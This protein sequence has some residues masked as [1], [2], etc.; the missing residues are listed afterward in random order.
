MLGFGDTYQV[1]V[2][3]QAIQTEGFDDPKS[4]LDEGFG[5]PTVDNIPWENDSAIRGIDL[6]TA[7]HYLNGD[8]TQKITKK[9]T[10]VIFGLNSE[11]PQIIN[12]YDGTLVDVE[13]D[14]DVYAYYVPNGTNYD[15]YFLA[16]SDIYTPVNSAELMNGMTALTKVDT[17]NL[18]VSRTEDMTK[19][20]MGCTVLSDIDVSRWDT[21]NVTSLFATFA[22]CKA[23]TEPDMDEWDTSNVTTLRALFSGC[24]ALKYVDVGDWNTSKVTDMKNIF[25]ACYKLTEVAGIGSWDTSNVTDMTQAFMDC[26]SLATLDVSDWNVGKVTRFKATFA[27]TAQNTGKM[28]LTDLDVTDWDVS[29]VTDLEAMFYGCGQITSMDLS[30]WDVSKVTKAAHMFSDC[31][32]LETINVSGWNTSSLTCLDAMFNDC[33]SLKVIDVS[34]FTTDKVKEFSQMFEVCTSL[35]KIIGLENWNTT[36]G[37]DFSEMFHGCSSLKELDLSSFDTRQSNAGYITYYPSKNCMFERFLAGCTSLEKISFS[38]NVS[39]DG[40]GSCPAG[41]KLVMPASTGVNGWDGNWYHAATGEAFAP[42]DIPE[43]TA[44]TYVAVNPNP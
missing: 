36:S 7:L 9:I 12:T 42:A 11:Y 39:F 26:V 5:E 2:K 17:T 10:N 27:T 29:S 19:M 37:Q 14:V 20:F 25:N 6:R 16:N 3:T 28:Q 23:L 32:K 33:R 15:V 35:E 31:Y 41:Y 4:A 8:T 43:E 1:L 30:K 40:D 22:N 24:N 38:A 18:N 13:Q 34:S 44:A 21:S